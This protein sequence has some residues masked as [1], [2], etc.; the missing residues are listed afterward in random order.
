MPSTTLHPPQTAKPPRHPLI[1]GVDTGGTFTDFVLL[2]PNQPDGD[3]LRI[4]KVLSTPAAPEAA[5]LQ[6]I[7]ELGLLPQI[8]AGAVAIVHGSVVPSVPSPA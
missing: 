5:I 6:G 7:E 2:D 3:Q 4:H 8:H 1:L